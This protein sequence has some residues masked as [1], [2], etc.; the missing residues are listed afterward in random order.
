MMHVAY[1]RSAAHDMLLAQWMQE[2]LASGDWEKCLLVAEKTPSW[3]FGYFAGQVTLRFVVEHERIVVAGWFEPCLGKGAFFSLWIAPE[4]RKGVRN[5]E[6]VG[7]LLTW[8]FAQGLKTI[9]SITTQ[10]ETLE[11]YQRM[12]YTLLGE[13]PHLGRDG[14]VWLLTLTHEQLEG[15]AYGRWSLRKQGAGRGRT[16]TT[17]G[18]GS[19]NGNQRRATA[20]G[21]DP[22]ARS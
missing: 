1:N 12:G 10:A 3:F 2:L 13:I 9:L 17:I 18:G 21:K 14:P 19:T 8:A 15:G 7:E 6:A 16:L 20:S 5:L 11:V 22:T 4:W